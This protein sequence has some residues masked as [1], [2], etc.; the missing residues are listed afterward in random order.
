MNKVLDAINSNA[1]MGILLLCHRA[2]ENFDPPDGLKYTRYG[3]M[4]H[5]WMW[6]L[7]SA[8]SD[9]TLM[10]DRVTVVQEQRGSGKAKAK[11]GTQRIL[12]TT[13]SATHDGKN[14]Y[15]LPEVIMLSNKSAE[16]SVGIFQSEFVKAIS[17]RK[18]T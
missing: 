9:M 18:A 4:L 1:N 16:E 3:P 14:R 7:T 13:H 8:W 11:G 12:R 17:E 5:K 6:D 10:L 15:G 2:I